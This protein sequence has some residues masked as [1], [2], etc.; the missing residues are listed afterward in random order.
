MLGFLFSCHSYLIFPTVIIVNEALRGWAV[1]TCLK[2][3]QPSFANLVTGRG[4]Y[5]VGNAINHHLLEILLSKQLDTS[6]TD[7]A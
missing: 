2:T 6:G 7:L 4:F 3:T 1:A 5:T